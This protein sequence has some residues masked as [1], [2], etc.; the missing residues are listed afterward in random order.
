MNLFPL[1]FPLDGIESSSLLKN[2]LGGHCEH[3]EAIPF[4]MKS[5]IFKVATSLTLLATTSKIELFRKPL[6]HCAPIMK[7]KE[8]KAEK[9]KFI[10]RDQ[11][12]RKEKPTV[13]SLER[14]RQK[15]EEK[16][17]MKKKISGQRSAKIVLSRKLRADR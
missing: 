1:S 4:T 14:L 17:W 11:P 13:E 3:R 16:G 2:S 6:V 10:I 9:R 5:N 8:P 12:D 7:E 15:A